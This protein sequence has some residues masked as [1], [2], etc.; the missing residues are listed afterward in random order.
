M[1][2]GGHNNVERHYIKLASEEEQVKNLVL[3]K[4]KDN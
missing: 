1:G 3:N 4:G 2:V